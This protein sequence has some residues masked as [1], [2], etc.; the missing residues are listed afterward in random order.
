MRV[1]ELSIL[2]LA[3]VS[4]C[5]AQDCDK[6]RYQEL[7]K[8]TV[9]GMDSAQYQEYSRLRETCGDLG[10]DSIYRDG[11]GYRVNDTKLNASQISDIV[12]RN[13]DASRF[14]RTGRAFSVAARVVLGLSSLS[15]SLLL[16][17]DGNRPYSVPI[18]F[19]STGL[20]TGL[21]AVGF[22]SAAI[23]VYNR[24]IGKK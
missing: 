17:P 20:L 21:V 1:S 9:K 23:S 15:C 4:M 24:D 14:F 2:F 11:F 6:Q 22:E 12:L 3:I 19:F 18:A 10:S 5:S 8:I 7:R 16:I 13:P